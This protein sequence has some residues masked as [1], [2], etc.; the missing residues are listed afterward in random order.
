MAHGNVRIDEGRL[1]REFERVALRVPN[2][3]ADVRYD[4]VITGKHDMLA[5]HE[6]GF[7]IPD[8]ND[9]DGVL[10]RCVADVDRRRVQANACRILL[11][12]ERVIVERSGEEF[13]DISGAHGFR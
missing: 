5:A 12:V 11:A 1:R 10:L 3:C 9:L 6:F 4:R 13:L 8:V 2:I 7:P